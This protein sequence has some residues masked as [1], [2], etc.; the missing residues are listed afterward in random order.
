M[1]S[2]EPLSPSPSSLHASLSTHSGLFEGKEASYHS[3]SSLQAG[4]CRLA[5]SL[6]P[7]CSEGSACFCSSLKFPRFPGPIFCRGL[8]LFSPFP[9]GGL[10]CLLLLPRPDQLTWM[11]LCRGFCYASYGKKFRKLATSLHTSLKD[12]KTFIRVNSF[13]KYLL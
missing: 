13:K 12:I 9:L 6:P 1:F 5:L 3:I 8:A 7:S 11:G 4:V 10:S 2:R